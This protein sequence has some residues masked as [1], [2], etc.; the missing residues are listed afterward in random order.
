MVLGEEIVTGV[1]EALKTK[2]NCSG[3][4]FTFLIIHNHANKPNISRCKL[5]QPVTIQSYLTVYYNALSTR[6]PLL[7]MSKEVHEEKILILYG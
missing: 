3:D 1:G 2:K 5:H 4:G 6:N 7:L